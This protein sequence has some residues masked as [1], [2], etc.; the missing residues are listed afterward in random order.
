M[1]W[2][3]EWLLSV[4]VLVE[5]LGAEG[6][7]FKAARLHRWS[8]ASLGYLKSSLCHRVSFLSDSECKRLA[9]IPQTAVAVYAA[10]PRAGEKLLT[11][12]PDSGLSLGSPHD[13]VI[14]LDPSP[15][16]SFGHPVTV[17]YVDF[18][19]NER[20]CGIREGLYLGNYECMTLALKSRC[21]N[22]LKRRTSRNERHNAKDRAKNRLKAQAARS[23]LKREVRNAGSQ[24]RREERLVGLCEIH[25]IPLVVGQ[26][27]VHKEQ[28]LRCVEQKGFA[29]CPRP[30]SITS[31]N[32]A[33]ADCELNKNTRRCHRQQLSSQKSC[34]MYQTCD[35]GVLLSGGW[36]EHLTYQRHVYNVL[37]FY[38][39]LR[40]NGFRTENIKTFF[41]GDGQIPVDEET[42]DIYPATEKVMIRSYISYIC[43]AVNCADSLVLYLN[44]PT[45]NDGT[46]LLWDVNKNGIADQK[47]KY[48]VGELLMDLEGCNARRVLIF[49]DQSYPGTL[50][51]KLLSSKKHPNVILISNSRGSEFTWASCFTEFWAEL[52]PDQCLIDY[53]FKHVAWTA[54]S[55]LGVVESTSGL[56]NSTIYGGPCYNNPPLTPEE[57]KREYMGCQNL[58]TAVWYQTIQQ[59]DLL[60]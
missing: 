45:R 7:Q 13:A 14:T 47:E 52:Q 43:R 38:R 28:R 42:E 54:P 40:R 41:A 60:H 23:S 59:K 25:F 10:E 3:W 49:V 20:R 12:L 55:T 30:L 19:V 33:A 17:F 22:L 1:N 35:H 58:P 15:E 56:L 34:R 53:L 50:V 39:M 8:T 6:S 32:P 24:S 9:E 21:E 26:K 27:D 18:N 57:V 31:P 2:R 37:H 11:I 4:A 48:T 46:M 44:S 5:L 29:A 51:K 16:L 36:K